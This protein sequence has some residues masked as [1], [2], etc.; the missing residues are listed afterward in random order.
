MVTLYGAET[1]LT[2]SAIT[3]PKVNGFGYNLE[4]CEHI[5]GGWSWQIFGA[6]RTIATV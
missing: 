4:H 5:V 3:P 2:R 6:I 1:V